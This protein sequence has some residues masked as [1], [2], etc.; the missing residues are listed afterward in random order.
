MGMFFRVLFLSILSVCLWLQTA[1]AAEH[2]A[3]D[4]NYSVEDIEVLL[5]GEWRTDT[6]TTFLGAVAYDYIF[7]GNGT[8]TG[9][10]FHLV[11]GEPETSSSNFRWEVIDS[12]KIKITVGDALGLIKRISVTDN[13][14]IILGDD[15]FRLV[16][17]LSPRA[18]Q[19]ADGGEGDSATIKNQTVVKPPVKGKLKRKSKR[20]T[21]KK[22]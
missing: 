16:R 8:G 3:A 18:G 10:T 6:I 11:L 7:Y 1:K 17:K 15:V 20:K 22:R 5:V 14:R 21:T 13:S 12:T 4:R 19:K 9:T 2:A